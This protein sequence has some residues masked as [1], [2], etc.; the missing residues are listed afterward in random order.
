MAVSEDVEQK[1]KKWACFRF[2]DRGMIWFFLPVFPLFLFLVYKTI[3]QET[4]KRI[5]KMVKKGKYYDAYDEC[6]RQTANSNTRRYDTS[7]VVLGHYLN[8]DPRVVEKTLKRMVANSKNIYIASAPG[9]IYLTPGICEIADTFGIKHG[10]HKDG[11][12]M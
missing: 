5:Q 8:I 2:K 3:S 10:M 4:P 11:T 7:I 1:I 6:I 9:F 12:E